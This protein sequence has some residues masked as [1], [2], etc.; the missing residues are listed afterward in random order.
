VADQVL[1]LDEGAIVE[2]GPADQV[3][4]EPREERTR[5]FLQRVLEPG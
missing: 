2:R 3:I 4:G 1:F 5:R